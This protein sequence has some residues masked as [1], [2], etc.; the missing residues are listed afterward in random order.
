MEI[1]NQLQIAAGKIQGV[2]GLLQVTS[3]KD[4]PNCGNEIFFDLGMLL[5]KQHQLITGIADQ[6]ERQRPQAT[7]L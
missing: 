4:F 5:E 6:I 2:A 7:A 3:A 1:H